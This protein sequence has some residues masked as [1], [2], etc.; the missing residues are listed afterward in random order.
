MIDSGDIRADRGGLAAASI[1]DSVITIINNGGYAL[2]K[3]E[4]EQ[5]ERQ[6]LRRVMQDCAG[7]EWLRLVRK[8]EDE[9]DG[10]GLDS[11][12]TALLT[13]QYRC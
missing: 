10:F 7:L 8:Q 9:S 6:Y 5:L 3:A 12:Y 2:N 4:I 1:S 13:H 11:V